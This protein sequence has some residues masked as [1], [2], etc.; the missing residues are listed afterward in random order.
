[1]SHRRTFSI[2]A[3]A[4]AG[5]LL[6][7]WVVTVMGRDDPANRPQ[8]NPQRIPVPGIENVFRLSPTLYSGGEAR[9]EA[10]LAALKRLGIKTLI[11]VDGATPDVENARKLGLRYVHLPVGYDGIS[12][13]EASRIIKAAQTLSGP[14]YI[15]CHHGIHRGPTAAGLCGMALEGWDKDR[16]LS[17]MKTVGTAPDYRGLFATVDQFVKPSPEELAKLP[18]AFPEKAEPSTLVNLMV[19]I[20]TRWDLLK[21]CKTAGFQPPKTRPDLD[22][23][24]EALQLREQFEELARQAK[25]AKPDESFAHLAQESARLSAALEQSLRQFGKEPSREA[26]KTVETAFEAVSRS[27]KTCHSQ[28]RDR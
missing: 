10:R 25:E 17:W 24:H 20:D 12:R 6:L 21:E 14:V 5:S 22:L 19:A 11:S 13:A 23:P 15:H 28:H 4:L 27:C 8:G 2:G 26:R 1:M 16:A 7:G 18:D 9:G 3:V